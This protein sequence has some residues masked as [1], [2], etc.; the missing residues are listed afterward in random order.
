MIRQTAAPLLGACLLFAAC[1]DEER[2]PASSDQIALDDNRTGEIWLR[3]T[4]RIDPAVWLASREQGRE[5]AGT[6]PAVE[7]MREALESAGAHFLE[8]GR[9]LA[10]RT[11][12]TGAMLEADGRKE[13]YA[14]LIAALTDVAAAAG[15]KQ[16]FGQLC[17]HYY[18]LRRKGVERAEALKILAERYQTQ[19]Q[20]R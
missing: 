2:K 6:E 19:K 13:S 20:F 7:E 16:T 3:A 18:N 11:A 9:M 4:D 12:Q 14:A 15:A 5:L 10:N 1:A 8:S 17:Q